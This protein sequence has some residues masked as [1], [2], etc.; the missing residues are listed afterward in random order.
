VNRIVA[1]RTLRAG[2]RKSRDTTGQKLLDTSTG[3]VEGVPIDYVG[4]N[5]F[6][7]DTLAVVGDFSMAVVGIRADLSWKMLDQAVITDD[8]GKVI[9]NLPQQDSQAM[10]VTARF[11]FVIANPM[12]RSP[13]VNPF[14]FGVLTAPAGP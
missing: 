3:S 11:G 14:P 9:I 6:P 13:E 12:T 10:R 1:S 4:F 5:V 2:L 8:T 7:D